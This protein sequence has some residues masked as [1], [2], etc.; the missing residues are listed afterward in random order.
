VSVVIYGVGITTGYGLDG[1]GIES[2]WGRDFFFASVQIGPGAYPTSY[3]IISDFFPGVKRPGRDVNHPPPPPRAEVKGRVELYMFS[4]CGPSSLVL[5][6]TVA[7]AVLYTACAFSWQRRIKCT[8][9]FAVTCSDV[10]CVV[11]AS[12]CLVLKKGGI[13]INRCALTP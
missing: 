2:R 8:R 7:F 3:T 12:Y 9:I 11:S 13:Y 1:P 6:Q 5:G 4:P 10:N